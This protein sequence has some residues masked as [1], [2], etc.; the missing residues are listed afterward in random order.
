MEAAIKA[1]LTP[2]LTPAATLR[3]L[4]EVNGEQVKAEADACRVLMEGWDLRQHIPVLSERARQ[5]QA[6]S[7]CALRHLLQAGIAAG[8]LRAQ[9]EVGGETRSLFATPHGLD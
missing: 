8:E 1:R 6:R 3:V 4:I 9:L 7:V 2:D 5:R